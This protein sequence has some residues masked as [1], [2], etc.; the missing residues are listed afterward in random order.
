MYPT[1]V[2]TLQ[3]D[4][5]VIM[6]PAKISNTNLLLVI[7]TDCIV[8]LILICVQTIPHEFIQRYLHTS[9]KSFTIQS[10][11]GETCT[12]KLCE[13]G[14]TSRFVDGYM[15]FK[16]NYDFCNGSTIDMYLVGPQKL[17]FVRT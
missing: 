17:V 5:G 3:D 16:Q 11:E 8:M 10:M 7:L 14:S 2:S 1:F 12:M 6:Y 13:S 4:H 15:A 9:D